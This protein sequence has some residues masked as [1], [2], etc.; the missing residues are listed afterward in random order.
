MSA[1]TARLAGQNWTSCSR[2]DHEGPRYATRRAAR[3]AIREM[4]GARH[5]MREYRCIPIGGWWAGW[6]IARLPEWVRRGETG[7]QP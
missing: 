7:A 1:G 4:H 3:H 2:R 6:H 5:G